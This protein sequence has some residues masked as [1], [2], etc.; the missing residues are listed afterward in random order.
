MKDSISEVAQVGIKASMTRLFWTMLL[1]VGC[2]QAQVAAPAASKDA[3]EQRTATVADAPLPGGSGAKVGLVRGAL[4]RLDPIHD[5]LLVH[6]FGGGDLRIAFD[7]RTQFLAENAPAR[8]TGIPVGTV[9]SVDTVI[10]RGKL[11]ALTV[12]TGTSHTAEL[13]GQV[14]QYD[15]TRSRLTLRDP[16]SPE[17]ISLRV[18]P[19]TKIVNH[20]RPASALDLSSGMLV[21]VWWSPTQNAADNIEIL[22]APGNSFSFEGRIVG[23]DLRSHTLVLSNDSDQSIR[24]IAVGSLNATDLGLLREGAN[25]SIQ[26]VFDGDR[27]NARTVALVSSPNP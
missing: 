27:Y 23:V 19:G 15:A 20:G 16:M 26:A 7:P 24:E 2:A 12:R 3:A 5:Q 4:K 22:A 25:V 21:R 17:G 18:T 6:A 14:M 10:E 9:V 11:F 1:T 8:L 13:N